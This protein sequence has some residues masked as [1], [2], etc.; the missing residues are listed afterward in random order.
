MYRFTEKR[1]TRRSSARSRKTVRPP[2][3]WISLLTP[4][5]GFVSAPSP[6]PLHCILSGHM[7]AYGAR[8]LARQGRL[9]VSFEQIL[10]VRGEI[11]FWLGRCF[12]RGLLIN[13]QLAYLELAVL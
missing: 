5:P 11:R 8:R 2:P 1:Y 10:A 9:A 6:L 4:D 3:R 7:S 12:V 13:N